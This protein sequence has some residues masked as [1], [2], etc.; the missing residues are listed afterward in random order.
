MNDDQPS[1]LEMWMTTLANQ[2]ANRHVLEALG[3]DLTVLDE[4]N[5]LLHRVFTTVGHVMDCYL[6]DPSLESD[7]W[8]ELRKDVLELCQPGVMGQLADWAVEDKRSAALL[9]MLKGLE[10]WALTDPDED[11]VVPDDPALYTEARRIV[12]QARH[13]ETRID[14]VQSQLPA[15]GNPYVR[16]GLI[17]YLRSTLTRCDRMSERLSALGHITGNPYN[18]EMAA[19]WGAQVDELRGVLGNSPG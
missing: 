1:Q 17:P 4:R 5:S 16:R 19:I 12:T 9:Q 11:E 10:E 13:C 6:T 3:D 7:A 2:E 18:M 14:R 15:A 8:A